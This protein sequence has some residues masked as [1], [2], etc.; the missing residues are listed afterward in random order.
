M[1]TV[2]MAGRPNAAVQGGAGAFL[3]GL[4]RIGRKSPSPHSVVTRDGTVL[5]SGGGSAPEGVAGVVRKWANDDLQTALAL[6]PQVARDINEVGGA[7]GYGRE[8]R[9]AGTEGAQRSRMFGSTAQEQAAADLWRRGKFEVI[10]EQI[11]PW[12]EPMARA[13]RAARRRGQ[14]AAA[15]ALRACVEGGW[16]TQSR[17]FTAG[18]AESE[19]C[20]C[21]AAAGTLWHKLGECEKGEEWRKAHCRAEVLRQG[22]IG[23]WDPLYSRGVPARPKP[24]REVKTWARWRA[25]QKG[26]PVM[27]TGN[28]YTDG[29]A[30]GGWWR[31]TRA[32]WAMVVKDDEGNTIGVLEW[33][34]RR[35]HPSKG[36]SSPQ[37]WKL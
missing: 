17:R 4:R 1:K 27:A 23:V 35:G 28:V 16:W 29:S 22:K 25:V 15:S 3:A 6:E 30:V 18:E 12:F 32:A 21:G 20:A 13:M 11:V 5:Y 26:A 31:A 34:G 8:D 37:Y 9:R 19:K 36:R 2:M 33:G 14:R 10:K 24:V 7:R